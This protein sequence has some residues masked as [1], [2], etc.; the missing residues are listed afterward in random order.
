MKKK[1]L[2]LKKFV[3]A[4]Q[5][6]ITSS[7]EQLIAKNLALFDTYFIEEE[8]ETTDTKGQMAIKKKLIAKTVALNY[9]QS[10][11][12]DTKSEE[13]FAISKDPIEVPLL[14]LIPL[15]MYGI[16]KATF[17]VEFHVAVIEDEVQLYFDKP[18]ATLFRKAP[19]TK[20]SKLKIKFN[21]QD[22]PEGLKLIN[23]CYE[24][25]LKRQIM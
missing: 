2:S 13:S 20:K 6:A 21:P 23:E 19:K 5:T 16:Q 4:V 1:P 17:A 14:S 10:P 11:S 22:T 7:N 15:N 25:Y 9:P 8:I 24:N 12:L 3:Q 18:K